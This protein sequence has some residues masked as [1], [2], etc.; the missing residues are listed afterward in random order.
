MTY[1]SLDII[2][3]GD[4]RYIQSSLYPS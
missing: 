4:D 3:I 2:R 1:F